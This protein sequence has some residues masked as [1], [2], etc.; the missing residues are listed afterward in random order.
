[1]P[2]NTVVGSR[3]APLRCQARRCQ[4]TPAGGGSRRSITRLGYTTP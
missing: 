3:S 4:V 2:K 1:M